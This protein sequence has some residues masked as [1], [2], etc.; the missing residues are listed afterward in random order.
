MARIPGTASCVMNRRIERIRRVSEDWLRECGDDLL[1]QRV[2]VGNRW[3]SAVACEEAILV[4]VQK[5]FKADL[6]QTVNCSHECLD[7]LTINWIMSDGPAPQG[8]ATEIKAVRQS[9]Q[10]L[11]VGASKSSE[12]HLLDK[13]QLCGK[14]T[15]KCTQC[16]G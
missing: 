6:L 14:I 8:Q 4:K 3:V 16:V 10:R 13:W 5:T 11:I 9:H 2:V 15:Q 7:A 12:V 1:G